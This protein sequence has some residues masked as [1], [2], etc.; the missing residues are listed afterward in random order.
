M[1][2]TLTLSLLLAARPVIP[3]ILNAGTQNALALHCVQPDKPATRAVLFVHGASF[4]TRVAAGFEFS[5]GDSWLHDAAR[6]GYLACGLDFAGFGASAPPA[7]MRHAPENTSPVARSTDAARQIAAAVASLVEQDVS[8]IHLVAHSWGTVPAAQFAA[9]HPDALASLTLF[10]PVVPTGEHAGDEAPYAWYPLSASVRYEHLK[11]GDVLP[12][13]VDLLE[14]AV[15][16]RWAA[17]FVVSANDAL[18]EPG[19][20]LRIPAGPA[21]DV[22]AVQSGVLPYDPARIRTPLLVVYGRQDTIVNRD[23]AAPFIDAFANSRMKW[24]VQLD[25]GTHVMHLEKNRRSLY[26]SVAAFIAAVDHP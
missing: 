16:A 6:R 25:D 3:Q 22:M 20:V 18:V 9:E 21:F 7:A 24:H 13:G 15:H 14:P 8:R 17:A 19:D 10:G 11:Y 5:P 1:L 26:E 2:S 4:P 12:A 23:T